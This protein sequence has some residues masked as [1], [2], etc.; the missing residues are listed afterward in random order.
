MLKLLK[1]K[2]SSYEKEWVKP[3]FSNL[4][5]F[6]T[7]L[8]DMLCQKNEQLQ[9]E[10]PNNGS[11]CLSV[12]VKKSANVLPPNYDIAGM[13]QSSSFRLEEEEESSSSNNSDAK[14]KHFDNFKIDN[15]TQQAFVVH[16][17]PPTGK[18]SSQGAAAIHFP[19][20]ENLTQLPL[21]SKG[22]HSFA[23]I[24]SRSQNQAEN[25]K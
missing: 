12:I 2:R 10:T 4:Q 19:K 7:M 9:L 17:P 25:K 13:N 5:E 14:L 1:L 8:Q 22:L 20:K 21:K 3:D 18:A 23:N 11:Q 16:R 6:L 24:T 15:W